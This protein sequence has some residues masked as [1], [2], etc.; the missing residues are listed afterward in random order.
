MLMIIICI[1]RP[2]YNS[3]DLRFVQD[4]IRAIEQ[5]STNDFL[6]LNSSKC[7]YMLISRARNPTLP[8]YLLILNYCKLQM[9]ISW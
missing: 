1:Y 8:E 4:D 7:K 5:W 3:S 6:T 9:L 2:I